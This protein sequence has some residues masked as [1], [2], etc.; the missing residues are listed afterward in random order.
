VAPR[1]QQAEERREQ[2]LD[3][4]LRVFSQKGF[5]G[6]S[7]RHI[8]REAGITEGLIY[9]YFE[10]K[11]QLQQACW[12]E[13]SWHSHVER[14]LATADGKPVEQ[15]LREIVADFLDTLREHGPNIR[16][17]VAEMQRNA[18]MA[19]EQVEKIEQTSGLIYRFLRARQDA[20]ELR[21]DAE[22]GMAAG[23]LL[24]CAHS[25]FLIWGDADAE[26]WNRMTHDLVEHGVDSVLHGIAARAASV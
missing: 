19:A 9:H 11:E 12:K 15:V 7:I 16:M 21:A 8:A 5:A 4:A 2:I 24:G 23:L 20:G 13:R 22:V 26:R 18:E 6:A 1:R 14:I 17:C 25:L 10:S 3:S